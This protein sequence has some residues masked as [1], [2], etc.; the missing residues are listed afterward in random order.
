MIAH[1]YIYVVVVVCFRY[2]LKEGINGLHLD[3][4]LESPLHVALNRALR[5]EEAGRHEDSAQCEFN[6]FYSE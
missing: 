5:Y 3:K 1:I 6:P 2:L 4:A